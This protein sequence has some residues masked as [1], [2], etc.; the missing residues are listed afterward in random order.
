[1]RQFV[2]KDET[3]LWLEQNAPYYTSK[4]KWKTQKTEYPYLSA[5]QTLYRKLN[6]I[7]FSSVLDWR[8]LVNA[9]VDDGLFSIPKA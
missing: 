5:S 9:K 2:I 7:P 1:M 3:D 6:E 4:D 8:T